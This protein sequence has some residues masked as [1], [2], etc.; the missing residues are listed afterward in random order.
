META[1]TAQPHPRR[2]WLARLFGSAAD[3]DPRPLY[4]A[5]VEAARTP[6]WYAD[7]GVP[8]TIDGR[9]DMVALML[10]LVLVRLER[11]G[12]AGFAARL[13]EQFIAD[14]DGQVRQIGFGD[15]AVGKQVGAMTAA[16]GGRLGSYRDGVTA[17]G[18]VR[19]VWR[20][21]DPRSGQAEALSVALASTRAAIDA[22]PLAA[23]I[24]G[25]LA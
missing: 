5:V 13:T 12:E 18:L 19:N 6:R 16:L 8:D 4:A 22:V 17:A 3:P 9:F 23:L 7:F 2:S 14:M 25:R 24:A 15:L 21:Q 11:G 10:T 20:G 1:S